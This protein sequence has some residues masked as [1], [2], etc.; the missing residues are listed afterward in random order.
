MSTRDE[1]PKELGGM[2]ERLEIGPEL[3]R[4]LATWA[5]YMETRKD[6]SASTAEWRV[7]YLSWALRGRA[8]AFVRWAAANPDETTLKALAG[9]RQVYNYNWPHNFS[10]GYI[11]GWIW[12]WLQLELKKPGESKPLS[13]AEQ[14]DAI[15]AFH[16]AQGKKVKSWSC[17]GFGGVLAQLEDDPA[18]EIEDQA[19]VISGWTFEIS[20]PPVRSVLPKRTVDE[21]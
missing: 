18:E 21:R 14:M 10:A 3:A 16:E 12:G 13:P 17:D 15:Q 9:I 4:R 6:G 2:R 1:L 7:Q 5:Q 8:E 19:C 20:I 11:F